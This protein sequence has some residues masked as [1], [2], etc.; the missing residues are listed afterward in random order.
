M[1]LYLETNVGKKKKT[2]KSIETQTGYNQTD[3]KS[4]PNQFFATVPVEW[5]IC[6]GMPF[7]GFTIR[8]MLTGT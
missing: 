3:S 6:V 5:F 8:D 4:F 2:I 1:L 7:Q